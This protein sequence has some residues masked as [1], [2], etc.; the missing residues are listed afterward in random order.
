MHH[1]GGFTL[2]CQCWHGNAIMGKK[3]PISASYVMHFPP[4]SMCGWKRRSH[5]QRTTGQQEQTEVIMGKL[6]T[7]T[8]V[9]PLQALSPWSSSSHYLT[10]V[11]LASLET[12]Q[13][14][15]NVNFGTHCPVQE[16]RGHRRCQQAGRCKRNREIR[17]GRCAWIVN[18]RIQAGQGILSDWASVV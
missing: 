14:L 18:V 10:S 17:T 1:D 2:T 7:S 8:A 12:W 11:Y 4:N 3:H 9:A 16:A 13:I 5:I 6:C 15:W